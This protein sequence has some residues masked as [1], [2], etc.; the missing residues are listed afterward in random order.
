MLFNRKKRK[1]KVKESDNYEDNTVIKTSPS[2]DEIIK[3]K[4]ADA[5][6]LCKIKEEYEKTKNF[7]LGK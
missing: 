6:R 5:E 2:K 4:N 3:K 7:L 1:Q